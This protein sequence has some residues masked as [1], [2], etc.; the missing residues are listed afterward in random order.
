MP[1][2]R[3]YEQQYLPQ[4]T[5][6]AQASPDQMGAGIGQAISDLGETF[7]KI[8]QDKGETWAYKN[9]GDLFDKLKQNY[10][11]EIAKLDPR[12]PEY[13]VKVN[14]VTANYKPQIAQATSSLMEQAPSGYARKAL[15]KY[16]LQNSRALM[17]EAVQRQAAISAE[18]MRSQLEDTIVQDA[19]SI[20]GDPSDANFN[21]VLQNRREMIANIKNPDI[22]PEMKIKWLQD[23]T[24]T[25]ALAQ[26]GAL[27]RDNPDFFLK[28]ISPDGGKIAAPRGDGTPFGDAVAFVLEKEGGYTP[29]DGESGAPANF[30][31]NQRANPDIDVKNLTQDRAVQIYKERYWNAIGG[32]SLPKPMAMVAFNVAVNMGVGAAKD[33]LEKSGGD[34]TRFTALA[35]QRYMDIVANNPKQEKYLAGWLAR[36]DATLAAAGA[37]RNILPQVKMLSDEQIASSSPSIAG[38]KYLTPQDVWSLARTAEGQ[39]SQRLSIEQAELTSALKDVEAVLIDGK[40]FPGID[41]GRFSEGNLKRVFGDFK[42]GEVYKQVENLKRVSPMIATFSKMPDNQVDAALKKE[43]P[44]AGPDYAD[45]MPVY[46][47]LV[48][49]VRAA[50]KN[51]QEDYMGWAQA[52]EGT[53]VKPLDY[54]DLNT[55]RE[56]IVARIPAAI[57]ARQAHGVNAGLLSKT[58]VS[59]LSN[60]INKSDAGT[61][62]EIIKQMRAATLNHDDLY[63][64]MMGQLS[65]NVPNFAVAGSLSIKKGTVDTDKGTVS[66]DAVV[67]K[68]V[69]GSF[70]LKGNGV[71]EKDKTPRPVQIE[72]SY[73]LEVFN[74]ATAGLF[75]GP[76][77]RMS[78]ELRSQ[79]QGAVTSYVA[80]EMIEN[81]VVKFDNKFSDASD[82]VNR[83]VKAIT[84]GSVSVGYRSIFEPAN[85][86]FLPWGMSEK[87]FNREFPV[88]FADAIKANPPPPELKMPTDPNY[89]QFINAG[90]DGEYKIVD[91]YSKKVVFGKNG[92]LVIKMS[93]DRTGGKF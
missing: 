32:D 52:T 75:N 16:M 56:S 5:Y 7:Q 62:V 81:G 29:S 84:G 79:Y 18:Y 45:K 54:T 68:I 82:Y 38:A 14:N 21:R 47:V 73:M 6:N 17:G 13:L 8:E 1:E 61:T 89:L 49:G 69:N 46:K 53:N 20:A 91:P 10:N 77:E 43:M 78:A 41:D 42:G 48:E 44:V 15:D 80:A 55:L 50:R 87:R 28:S 26:G 72:P 35:K 57:Q 92:P 37:P 34:P 65:E 19:R 88:A 11:D 24:R 3:T 33:L 70:I 40:A 71:D 85:K 60:M 23:T 27:A 36:A 51:R 64:Q 74:A 76:D 66:A 58:E 30:G 59:D 31:I 90:R 22:T 67:R 93:Q 4:G 25:L 83:A 39:M 12:D 2:I 86:V 9:A 63:V